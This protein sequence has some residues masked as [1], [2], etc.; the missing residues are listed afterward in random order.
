MWAAHN[1]VAAQV[2]AGDDAGGPG[3][4]VGGDEDDIA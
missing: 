4:S 1:A 3:G 2:V